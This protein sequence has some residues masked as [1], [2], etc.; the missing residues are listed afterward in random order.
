[1]SPTTCGRSSTGDSARCK[2]SQTDGTRRTIS[3]SLLGRWRERAPG[4]LLGADDPSLAW[5]PDGRY[6]F[7]YGGTGPFMVDV[8]CG[9]V[10]RYPNLYG[11]VAMV[12]VGAPRS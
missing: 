1:M 2:S 7:A 12:W 8:G 3:E 9:E 5:S 6:L 4:A 10:T 11:Y